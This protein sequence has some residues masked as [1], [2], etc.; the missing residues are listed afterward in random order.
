MAKTPFTHA[1][2]P[3]GLDPRARIIPGR[4]GTHKHGR[5]HFDGRRPRP[6]Q[7]GN[8]SCGNLHAAGSSIGGVSN[9]IEPLVFIPAVLGGA[10]RY[11]DWADAMTVRTGP[12]ARERIE[13]MNRLLDSFSQSPAAR[14]ESGP[15]A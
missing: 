13:P 11:F 1:G 15:R 4:R 3:A 5:I 10:K 14:K 6:I 8:L 12:G 7:R 9:R 2:E